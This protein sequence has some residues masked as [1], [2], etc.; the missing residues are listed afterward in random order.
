MDQQRV[1]RC[2]EILIEV[3]KQRGTITYGA[4][5]GRLGVANVGV[6]PY[7]NAVYNDLVIDQ[8]LP[9]LTL[10]AVS[11]GSQYG[12][13]NSRGSE[14]QSVPFNPSDPSQRALY[15]ADRQAVYQHPWP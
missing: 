14:A 1:D 11:S 13:Y 5:A 15:D 3:A 12:R 7:L 9:D 2:R 6:T 4:L 10:L 8:G